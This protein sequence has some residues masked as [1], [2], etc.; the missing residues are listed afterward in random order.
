MN[1]CPTYG[2]VGGHTFGY[3]YPGPIGIPWTAN[4]HGLEKANEFA[5][6]CISCGLCQEICPADINIPMMIAKTKHEYHTD[7]PQ[8]MVNRFL[9]K[10]EAMAKIGS[11]TAP[12][13]NWFIRNPLFRAFME[14]CTG[15]ERTREIPPFSRKT[16]TTWYKKHKKHKL[17]R[18][19]KRK[20][21]FF[22]D[23]YAN[24]NR[25]DIGRQ[26]VTFLERC[27][28]E[29]LLPEQKSCGYPYI[30]YGALDRAKEIA[31]YNVD[32]FAPL[33]N[34]RCDIITTE[35]TAAYCLIHSYPKLLDHSADSLQVSS[36][37]YE[38]FDY[39]NRL[40]DEQLIPDD[41][42]EDHKLGGKHFGF[43]LSCHQ[44]PLSAG[45][46]TMEWLRKLGAK[47]SLIETGTCCGM[48]GTFGMKSGELGY[49]LSQAVGEPLFKAF[50]EADVDAIVTESSVCRIHLREGTR[51]EV[52]HPLELLSL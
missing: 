44:R 35:P 19:F 12:I 8:P 38:L 9:M 40:L 7:H 36:H 34:E 28:C 45:K 24:Y 15:I 5:D 30:G 32:H 16:L 6:L 25:P 29:V 39:L 11:M 43:H 17:T 48:A 41:T 33:V 49:E 1:I 31:Q 20:V 26:V 50:N 47:V 4:V 51:F 27:G 46:A 14:K 23:I 10:A 3:I 42:L 2:V 37:T 13:S 21:A 52:F 22:T 18:E